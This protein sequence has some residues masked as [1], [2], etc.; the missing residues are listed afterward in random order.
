MAASYVGLK[1]P[2]FMAEVKFRQMIYGLHSHYAT[3]VLKTS[4]NWFAYR[5][6]N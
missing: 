5:A 2:N 3:P 6:A 1:V 4:E